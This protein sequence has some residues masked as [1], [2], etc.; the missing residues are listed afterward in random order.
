MAIGISIS[1]SFVIIIA[2]VLA[3][4]W[5]KLSKKRG[6]HRFRT[7]STVVPESMNNPCKLLDAGY[8]HKSSAAGNIGHYAASQMENSSS[9]SDRSQAVS[10]KDI[11]IDSTYLQLNS[12]IDTK[13]GYLNTCNSYSNFGYLS[14]GTS[15]YESE[16]SSARSSA[17]FTSRSSKRYLLSFYLN[18]WWVSCFL[19]FAPES[20]VCCTFESKSSFNVTLRQARPI[21]VAAT[22]LSVAQKPSSSCPTEL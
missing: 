7:P 19:H 4:A 13:D 16:N 14:E 2:M 22:G 11:N 9:V 5:F 8:L 12:H 10:S 18:V 6:E 17:N 15:G 1:I 21:Q 3:F 20:A